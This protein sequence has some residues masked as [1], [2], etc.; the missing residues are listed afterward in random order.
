M[1]SNSNLAAILFAVIAVFGLVTAT[2]PMLP[3]ISEAHAA[4]QVAHTPPACD[5]PIHH[6]PSPP[7]VS[8]RPP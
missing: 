2:L 7:C 5:N 3:I 8:T 1:N 4:P 6:P